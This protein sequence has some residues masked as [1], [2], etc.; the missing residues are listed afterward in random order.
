MKVGF[1]LPNI[2]RLGSAESVAEVSQRAE[3]L[4]YDSLWTIER[5]L[6]PVKPQTPYPGTPDG[7]LPEEYKYSL[8]PLDTLTFAAGQTKKV[9]LGTSVL[10]I[11]YYSPVM[12]ARRLSTIDVLSNGRLRVGFGLGWSKDEMDAAGANMKERGAR[13]DEF[14]QVLKAIWTTDPV[15]FHGKFFELPK[16]YMYPKPVQKPHPP[17]Y[18]AAFAP[19]ALKRV[20]MLADGWNPVGIPLDGMTQMFGAIQQMAKEAGRDPS[21]LK[22][23]VRANIEIKEKPSG[24]ERP[25]FNGTLDQIKEDVTGCKK[26]GAH[27]LVF[28]VTFY[29]RSL[30]QWLRL[31][32]ELRKLA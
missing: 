21:S 12:L 20:A 26:I 31:M 27:E 32:E 1:G 28:D 3:D 24:K 6:W 14:L 16:S 18:M 17:I 11:P 19:A 22:M 30:D 25:I 9:A 7:S 5:L 15:E 29:A 4:G 10:D 13:A 8:D 2:G 23:V